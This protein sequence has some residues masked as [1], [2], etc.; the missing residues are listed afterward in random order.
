MLKAMALSGSRAWLRCL[1]DL[2]FLSFCVRKSHPW[3]AELASPAAGVAYLFHIPMCLGNR[4]W[5]DVYS[6]LFVGVSVRG[7]GSHAQPGVCQ[8]MNV[9]SC[10]SV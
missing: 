4:A 6:A 10:V 9:C 8:C 5:L 2:G 1:F 3:P 7:L